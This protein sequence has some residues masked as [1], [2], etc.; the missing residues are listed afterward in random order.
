MSNWKNWPA[1]LGF[2]LDLCECVGKSI[3]R[4]EH[5]SGLDRK[6]DAGYVVLFSDGIRAWF[7]GY[8]STKQMIVGPWPADIRQSQIFTPEEIERVNE[9]E[10][11][12]RRRGADAE[13]ERKEQKYRRLAKELGYEPE[14]SAQA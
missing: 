2:V 4:V 13:Q 5:L 12:E 14:D 3:E 9:W 8:P 1:E 6:R 10:R 11:A 7:W